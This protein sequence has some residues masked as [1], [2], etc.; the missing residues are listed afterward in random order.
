M[1]CIL[2]ASSEMM[3]HYMAPACSWHACALMLSLLVDAPAIPSDFRSLRQKRRLGCGRL[4]QAAL[5]QPANALSDR[6]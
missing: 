6:S 4:C 1:R 5:S 2:H 3:P